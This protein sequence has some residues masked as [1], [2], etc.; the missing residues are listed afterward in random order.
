VRIQGGGVKSPTEQFVALGY[1]RGPNGVAENGGG[2]DVG[3]GP[4]QAAYSFT[5]LTHHARYDVTDPSQ[6]GTIDPASG[7]FT[8]GKGL[9]TGFGKVTATTPE[10]KTAEIPIFILPPD[11]VADPPPRVHHLSC[12]DQGELVRLQWIPGG[13]YL[14]QTVY[15]DGQPLAALA[16]DAAGYDD[17]SAPPGVH[18]YEVAGTARDPGR[19]RE[20]ESDPTPCVALVKRAATVQLLWAPREQAGGATDSA[21][22]LREAL[23]ANGEEVYQVEEITGVNLRDFRAVWAV[24]GTY[25]DEHYL[26]LSEAEELAGYLTRDHGKLYIEGADIWGFVPTNAFHRV[27]GVFDCP[28]DDAGCIG[29]DGGR[30]DLF[31]LRGADG[32]NGLDL[33]PFA[34]PVTYSGENMFIDRL[35]PGPAG[36]APVWFNADVGYAAGIAYR[37]PGYR[38]IECSF[39]FG[40]IE[41]DRSEVMRRYLLFLEAGTRDLYFIR[42]DVDQSGQL[43]ISD[44]IGLL[45]FLF[46]GRGLPDCPP[47]ADAN[48]DGTLEITDAIQILAFLFLGEPPPP[49][50]F[51]G[52]GLDPHPGR[53]AC[54]QHLPR[55]P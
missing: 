53:A 1:L 26:W 5:L 9:A 50:P 12:E 2:D 7:L 24:F 38:T 30:D 35:V 33:S 47:A 17:L 25:P 15:R 44:A 27:D 43:D 51:P 49:P 48:D 42:G 8:A 20:L 41:A 54:F 52:C 28:P 10:G 14:G 19:D 55:C 37:G 23:G 34:G 18:R 21:R 29:I 4:V 22:A 32:R 45:G 11:F 31:N 13:P 39:E 40:G 6:V 46:L 16:G 3:L 36:A